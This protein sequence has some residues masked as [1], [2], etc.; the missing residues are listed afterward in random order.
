M[1]ETN[2][3]KWHYTF[4]KV[5]VNKIISNF[6]N[7]KACRIKWL[8][9]E[10]RGMISYVQIWLWFVVRMR[11]TESVHVVIQKIFKHESDRKFQGVTLL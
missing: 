11:Q 5:H 4:F 3:T 7:S 8:Q 1:A 6:F 10:H 9:C 2:Q